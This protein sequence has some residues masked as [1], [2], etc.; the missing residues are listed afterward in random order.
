MVQAE[1]LADKTMTRSMSMPA[2]ILRI[3][4]AAILAITTAVYF[5]QGYTWWLFPLL[6]LAPDLSAIGY[7]FGPRVGSVIYNLAHTITVPLLLLG[8]GWWVGSAVIV[9]LAL[10]W[11]AHIGMDRLVGYGLKYPDSARHNHLHEV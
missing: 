9:P 4:G 11:L 7:L 1:R 6:L 3:E 5:T 2:A 10:I 8:C